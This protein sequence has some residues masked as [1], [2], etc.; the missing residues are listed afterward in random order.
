MEDTTLSHYVLT[1]IQF[2]R[3][4][5]YAY[6][7]AIMNQHG[8]CLFDFNE[9]Q[10]GALEALTKALHA[11]HP[12]EVAKEVVQTF[13]AFYFP[14]N[15]NRSA[16][17]VFAEPLNAYLALLCLHENGTPRTLSDSSHYCAR[18]QFSIRLR[19]FHHLFLHATSWLKQGPSLSDQTVKGELSIHGPYQG[20]YHNCIVTGSQ[21]N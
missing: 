4:M 13:H 1:E 3:W 21:G 6:H 20:I 8:K 18:L 7:Q 14:V 17:D 9:N 12:G 5:I 16:L 2:L 15:S 10:I 11:G 19:G